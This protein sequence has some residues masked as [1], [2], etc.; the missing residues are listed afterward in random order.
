MDLAA[1]RECLLKQG[2]GFGVI[3]GELICK[4]EQVLQLQAVS[5][6]FSPETFLRIAYA[7]S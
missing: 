4:A 7:C 2:F 3:S 6:W 1:N 5:G